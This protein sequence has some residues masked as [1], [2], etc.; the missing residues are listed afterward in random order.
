MRH[1]MGRLGQVQHPGVRAQG[2][3]GFREA[4]LG[5]VVP[6]APYHQGGC[7]DRPSRRDRKVLSEQGSVPVQHCGE[8][9]RLAPGRLIG[10]HRLRA[11]C[12]W[13]GRGLERVGQAAITA[14]PHH[15]FRQPGR[16]KH[17]HILALLSLRRILGHRLQPHGRMRRVEDRHALDRS[18]PARRHPPG[19]RR[20]PV[21]AD[22]REALATDS[23]GQGEDV[24]GQRVETIGRRAPGLGA[25]VVAAL[26]GRDH[27]EARRGQ[28]LDQLTPAEPEFRKP[29][30]QYH[31]RPVRGASLSHVQG[32]P[33][34]QDYPVFN[35]EHT[36]AALRSV[37]RSNPWLVSFGSSSCR[38]AWGERF[39]LVRQL[40]DPSRVSAEKEILRL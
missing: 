5:E 12:F 26:V 24:V 8:R 16:A 3:A 35:H 36:G 39:G 29:M 17:L 13:P 9:A 6:V 38:V 18:G 22:Q 30:Q 2:R 32:H 11:E 40:E 33:I 4:R 31:Q 28:W 19:D 23:L 27:P 10:R 14:G 1:P 20:A 7:E 15:Q 21:V 34:G 37:R 25:E